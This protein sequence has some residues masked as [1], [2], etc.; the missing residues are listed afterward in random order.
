MDLLSSVFSGRVPVR[1]SNLASVGYDWFTGVLEIEFRNGRIYEY[2]GVPAG[3]YAGLMAA[4][5]HGS[6]FAKFIRPK[7]NYSRIQ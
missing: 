5:S 4:G 6:Y 2:Y 3:Y 7:F 1:S